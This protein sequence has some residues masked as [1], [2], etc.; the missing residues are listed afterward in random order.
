[1]LADTNRPLMQSY[2]YTLL[3]IVLLLLI[4]GSVFIYSS[5]SVYALAYCGNASYFLKKQVIGIALGLIAMLI[6]IVIPLPLIKKGAPYFFIFTLCITCL[7]FVPYFKLR[8]H[9]SSR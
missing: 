8:I 3:F 5:S 6:T 9:G 4:V 7:S 1:M 2:T